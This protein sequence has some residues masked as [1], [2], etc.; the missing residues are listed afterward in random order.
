MRRSQGQAADGQQHGQEDA[1]KSAYKGI[2]CYAPSGSS[3]IARPG[4]RTRTPG[5]PA[6]DHGTAPQGGVRRHPA[7]NEQDRPGIVTVAH[8]GREGISTARRRPASLRPAHRTPPF[9]RPFT[10]RVP[11]PFML[12]H[13][14]KSVIRSLSVA[15]AGS[16]VDGQLPS[17]GDRRRPSPPTA[18]R[19]RVMGARAATARAFRLPA[20]NRERGARLPEGRRGEASPGRASGGGSRRPASCGKGRQP[21]ESPTVAQKTKPNVHI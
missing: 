6:A 3:A 5:R 19:T 11:A 4:R 17:A 14:R 18:A 9:V 1:H 2:Q 15:C 12:I 13:P 7:R 10:D 21:G 16:V 8:P 20:W